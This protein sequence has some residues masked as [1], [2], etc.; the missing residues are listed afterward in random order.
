MKNSKHKA[1]LDAVKAKGGVKYMDLGGPTTPTLAPQAVSTL[2][3]QTTQAGGQG[4]L[5]GLAS[6]FTVQNPYQAQLAPTTSLDYS[7][8]INQAAQNSL[9]GYGQSQ[10]N[11]AAEQQ[12][13]Q[14]LLAQSQGQ[15]P[16]PAQA[17]L[18]QNTGSNVANQA[19]L[20][21]GQR[22]G[23]ANVGLLQRQA[24]QQ[25][26][27]IQQNAVGQ[28]A[29]L[30]AQQ[31]LAAQ[32]GAA[33]LQGQIGNQ[34]TN[35]Q[36][37]NNQLFGA[38]AGSA[39]AQNNNLVGNYGM[40][41]GLNAQAAQNNA[42]AVGKTGSGILGGVGDLVGKG[43]GGIGSLIGSLFAEGGEV[44]DLDPLPP[45]Y[46]EGGPV[47]WAGQF[48]NSSPNE[49]GQFSTPQ[50]PGTVSVSTPTLQGPAP[51][52]AKDKSSGGGGMSSML[53]LLALLNKGG[54]AKPVKGEELASKGKIVPGKAKVKG[55]SLK[56]DTVPAMLS[57]GEIVIPKSI[58]EHPDAAN[59]AA[60]FV[61]Q[62]KAKQG[63]KHGK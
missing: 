10:G 55:D 47:S 54:S 29:T 49:M 18:A 63:L 41:Q 2:T 39:N 25:G 51:E 15:G 19:A 28:A 17:A 31:Q 52:P 3:P 21:A 35:Q 46:A 22:G 45:S 14:Q 36:A 27:G 33:A 16:N 34:I 42:N 24:A 26:S 23:A 50:E 43:I 9:A 12:L 6:Q 30:G 57:P 13:T 8:V 48:L 32:Q 44:K 4:L 61:M 5:G 7:P 11:I 60:Q 62:I 37:S 20:A 59:K 56:N 1:F 38:G 40:A 53:P 58:A